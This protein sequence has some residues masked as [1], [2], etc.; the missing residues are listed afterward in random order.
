MDR[1]K[2]HNFSSISS[3][4]DGVCVGVGFQHLSF[5]CGVCTR[6]PVISTGRIRSDFVAVPFELGFQAAGRTKRQ[7]RVGDV[8]M[9][10]QAFRGA[11]RAIREIPSKVGK[12]R[13]VAYFTKLIL[14]THVFYLNHVGVGLRSL[15]YFS[16]LDHPIRRKE[17]SYG[18]H[19]KQKLVFFSDVKTRDAP[20]VLFVPGG[21]WGSAN[22]SAYVLLGKSLAEHGMVAATISYRA[23]PDGGI[24][25]MLDDIHDGTEYVL[26]NC[27][28][29]G[30]NPKKLVIF[31]HSAGAQ[32]AFMDVLRRLRESK[33]Q[34]LIVVGSCGVYDIADHYEY[35]AWRGVSE[36]STMKPAMDGSENFSR[37][38]PSRLFSSDEAGDL[39]K[40]PSSRIAPELGKTISSLKLTGQ[41]W[42]ERSGFFAS[43]PDRSAAPLC[44]LTT[45]GRDATVP[46]HTSAQFFNVLKASG[47]QV[48]FLLYDGVEHS[49]FVVDWMRPTSRDTRKRLF[50][51]SSLSGLEDRS[52]SDAWPDKAEH[53]RDLLKLILGITELGEGETIT[54][55]ENG[56]ALLEMDGQAPGDMSDRELP[57]K[58][59]PRT[60]MDT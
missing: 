54:A 28:N 55:S 57:S 40:S 29:Y 22:L 35:E 36:M 39:L 52:L 42:A 23:Y 1:L 27:N 20:V 4:G 49:D 31:A 25:D 51:P 53:V 26:A 24:N 5:Y 8:R 41:T 56:R 60:D 9:S 13:F 37:F 21:A 50:V 19:D 17:V 44:I 58:K 33:Q 12:L 14:E 45:S 7:R 2:F 15:H 59:K 38:S 46:W 3:M 10:H 18:A 34:P 6:V 11:A 43:L 16:Q 32:L 47:A 30:G 48:L